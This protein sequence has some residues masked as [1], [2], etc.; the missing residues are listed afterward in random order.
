[1]SEIPLLRGGSV[2]DGVD[3][4]LSKGVKI[5][6]F[7]GIIK[8]PRQIFH[9]HTMSARSKPRFYSLNLSSKENSIGFVHAFTRSTG[10][11]PVDHE[12]E[13]PTKVDCFGLEK[14]D[15]FWLWDLGMVEHIGQIYISL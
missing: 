2:A 6:D 12:L 15:Q 5:F 3:T 13:I 4:H 1:V 10:Q 14:L 8:L 7:G 11:S 9:S